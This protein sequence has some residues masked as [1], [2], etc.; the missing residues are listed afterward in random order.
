MHTTPSATIG[1][2]VCRRYYSYLTLACPFAGPPTMSVLQTRKAEG[3]PV[4][5]S[6]FTMGEDG[7]D[8]DRALVLLVPPPNAIRPNEY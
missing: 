6:G 2:T 7:D 1:N 4:R 5:L 8:G 3:E